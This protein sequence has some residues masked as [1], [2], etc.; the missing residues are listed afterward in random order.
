[1]RKREY[2]PH[3]L[4]RRTLVITTSALLLLSGLTPVTAATAVTPGPAE[5]S[6]A[7]DEPPAAREDRPT[8]PSGFCT[9]AREHRLANS[10]HRVRLECPV[11]QPAPVRGVLDLPLWPDV[12]VEG[13]AAGTYYSGWTIASPREDEHSRWDGTRVEGGG[14][15][16]ADQPLNVTIE[17]QTG[18]NL[19][20]QVSVRKLGD[21]APNAQFPP[22]ALGPQLLGNGEQTQFTNK[23]SNSDA[24]KSDLLDVD[25]Y[26]FESFLSITLSDSSSPEEV[27][28]LR[29]TGVRYDPALGS[30]SNWKVQLEDA[31]QSTDTYR[32]RLET[33]GPGLTYKIVVE[34]NGPVTQLTPV[35]SSPEEFS[36]VQLT[37]ITGSK[38]K[39]TVYRVDIPEHV[40]SYE[41]LPPVI[42]IDPYVVYGTR[43]NQFPEKL[44]DLVSTAKPIIDQS[45]KRIRYPAATFFFE[46]VPGADPYTTLEVQG[47]PYF[48][49]P[50]RWKS[51]G[52]SWCLGIEVVPPCVTEWVPESIDTDLN[53]NR[54]T[55]LALADATTPPPA[56]P[57]HTKVS[58][59]SVRPATG[60]PVERNG[61]AQEALR[62]EIKASGAT[63]N[64]DN[65][66]ELAALYDNIYF[67]N[68]ATGEL[69]TN[70]YRPASDDGYTAI[71]TSRGPYV[72]T[73]PAAFSGT[74]NDP[75][76]RAYLSTTQSGTVRFTAHLALDDIDETYSGDTTS[77]T[78]VLIPTSVS[79]GAVLGTVHGL[80]TENAVA[81]THKGAYHAFNGE[82]PAAELLTR[83][84]VAPQDLA[85]TSAHPW[86]LVVVDGIAQINDLRGVEDV[87]KFW[88]GLV[89]GSGTFISATVT[90]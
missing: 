34:R 80:T 45:A 59:I 42:K 38:A 21:N 23:L 57:T 30:G 20:T 63:V 24:E 41:T 16:D 6:A 17:N 18:L 75:F 8:A 67:R 39:N 51:T 56:T 78:G 33:A 29:T 60:T 11:D 26:R 12:S 58:A 89:T 3:R 65:Q 46:N 35:S 22:P 47:Y 74:T 28:A 10:Q 68:A 82:Q 50:G 87:S 61:L 44:G 77:G 62:L 84:Y 5:Q 14:Y 31:S 83:Y 54:H 86:Q 79:T 73:L 72:N 2:T 70:L 64:P 7:A 48:R 49:S 71:S 88:A 81:D 27:H 66:P 36:P 40:R 69:I 53:P 15:D 25:E 43:T 52:P 37:R 32:L 76:N 90:Q 55:R 85:A 1:M 13:Q 9:A 4:T 19:T